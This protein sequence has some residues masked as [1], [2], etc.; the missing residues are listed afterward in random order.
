MTTTAVPPTRILTASAFAEAALLRDGKP[1]RFGSRRHLPA[2]YDD[3]RDVILKCSRQT[4]KSTSLANQAAAFL[5]GGTIVED[6]G[7]RRA[8]RLLYVSASWLQ[9][10]DFSKDRLARVLESPC[11]VESVGGA[12]PLWPRDR[13][14]RSRAFIDQ[15]GE[16]RLRSGASIKL[17][18]VHDNADRV[19]G[20]S[21]DVL[22]AD[23][24]Q[25]ILGDLFPVIEESAARSP[26][27]KRVY[28]GTPKTF[29]NAIERQWQASTRNEWILRCGACGRFQFL[30]LENL[31]RRW[32]EETRSGCICARCGRPLDPRAG[33]W[34]AHGD[35]DA[36]VHGYRI[37]HAMLPQSEEGWT[38]ILQKRETYTEQAFANE[39]LGFS[40]EHAAAV[41]TEAELFACCNAERANGVW[42]ADGV[43]VGLSAGVDW[44]GPGNSA[45][46]LTIGAFRDGLFRVL[47]VRNYKRYQGSRDDVIA[48]IAQVCAQWRVPVIGTDWAAGVKENADLRCAVVPGTTVVP[49]SYVGNV[50]ATARWDRKARLFAVNRTKTLSTVFQLIRLGR[51]E[52]FRREDLAPL[53]GGYTACFQEWNERTGELRFDH[54]DSRPDDE[55]HSLNYC[56]MAACGQTGR[57]GAVTEEDARAAT[58]G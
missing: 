50:T 6:D 38:A 28:A 37:C 32:H 16:K 10:T 25:D 8:I 52:F 47:F 41:L 23:E 57:F 39:V 29:D 13:S 24:I 46:V 22:F 53:A 33:R 42:P 45:T 48:N 43:A 3:P 34:V 1:F 56:Y 7:V 35:P 21:S 26:L 19:R 18:A 5:Y 9:V 31:G 12:P 20:I 58:Q 54:P 15:V 51:M 2:I 36:P 27:R 4:E 44:G 30:A 17:R 55:I 49:F 14:V 11:F 40:H